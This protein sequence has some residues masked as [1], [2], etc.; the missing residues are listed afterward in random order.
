MMF[1]L[2]NPAACGS[3]GSLGS[4][5]TV[6]VEKHRNIPNGTETTAGG[7]REKKVGT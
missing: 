5:V 3:G 2:M 6:A 7:S 1:I 4:G